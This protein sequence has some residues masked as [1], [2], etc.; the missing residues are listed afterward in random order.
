M[1]LFL[2]H[3]RNHLVYSVFWMRRVVFP[4]LQTIHWRTNFT[5]LQVRLPAETGVPAVLWE[6]LHTKMVTCDAG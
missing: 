6:Y 1:K 2:L 5:L 4:K 3:F